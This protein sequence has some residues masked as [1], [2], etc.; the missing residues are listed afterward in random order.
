MTFPVLPDATRDLPVVEVLPALAEALDRGNAVLVAPPGAGKTTLGPLALLDAPWRAGRKILVLEPRRLAARAAA[1]RLAELLGEPL[2]RR[3]GLATRLE[4]VVS[5]ATEIEVVTEG[6][7]V[8]RLQ[9]DPG[10]EGVG[11]I[12]FDE[13]HERSLETD[14]ALALA[15]EVQA[16][17]RP[18]LRLV[19]MSATLDAAA[20][21][22]L[23]DAPVIESA[24]RS[25]PVDVVWAARDLAEPRELA[26]AATAAIRRALAATAGDVLV[27]LPGMAEI[28]RVEALLAEDPS[29]GAVVRPLHGEL[30]PQAQD[31]ALRPD[32]AGRRKVIL[33]TAIAETSLTVEGVRVVVDGGF[34]RAPRFD[35]GS[36]LT[37]LATERISRASAEQ[38]AGRAGRLAPGV[39]FRLWTEALHRGLAVRDRPEILEADLAPLALD[40]AAWGAEPAALAFLDP[41][42][43]GAYAAAR[44]LLRRL[45]ALDSRGTITA[46]GRRMARLG[47]H[48]RLAA[49][50]VEAQAEEAGLACDLAALIE[51]R[52][53]LRVAPGE[54]P[55]ADIRLRL[56]RLSGPAAR[57]AALHRRR[58]GLREGGDGAPPDRAGALIARAFPDRVAMARAERGAFLLASGRGARLPPT[59]PL[60]GEPFL[61]VAALDLSGRE[62]RI[63]LAAPLSRAEIERLF[64]ADIVSEET[65]AWDEAAGAVRAR[66]RRSFGALV[67]EESAI[68]RPDP[69]LVAR[70]L[71]VGLR[72]RGLACLPW[73]EAARNLQAR[74]ALMRGLDPAWPD[75]S[76]EALLATLEDWLAPFLAGLSRLEELGGLDL[77]AILRAILGPERASELDRA[78]PS[79]IVLPGGGRAAIDYARSPPTLSARAQALFGLTAAPR[80]AGGRVPLQVELLSPAGRPIAVTGDLGAFWRGGWAEVRKAMRG[81]YPKHAWPED[82]SVPLSPGGRQASRP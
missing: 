54:V 65:V 31:L 60:A 57:A 19:A 28:R 58:L 11:A 50:L 8:R 70:G 42:P 51:E 38:R 27:F 37:R 34:R 18:D 10:L 71:C 1:R 33:A 75:L 17:L 12:L 20:F 79:H 43:E 67:L 76:D 47:A 48:P 40:L 53:A 15:R 7:L 36:G 16:A 64:A 25:F 3:V 63:R 9:A 77:V 62:A 52:D 41:P 23:L 35:P 14:L 81:R 59:D 5:A 44:D 30:S 66:R 73:T 45:G 49:M 56:G 69:A 13:V 78:L 32:A 6:L 68:P 22:R 4:R 72:A 26:E 46:K 61:A 74:A 82:P 55:P 2:G 39:C 29:L 80:L 21:A 24:G